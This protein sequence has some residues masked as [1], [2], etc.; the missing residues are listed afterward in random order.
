MT[1]TGTE[2]DADAGEIYCWPSG[3][4][5]VVEE[6]IRVVEFSPHDQMA[7]VLAHVV[8]KLSK[9]VRS[10][11]E[12]ARSSRTPT[13]TNWEDIVE[14]AEHITVVGQEAELL[15]H[16]AREGG[17][18]AKVPTCPGWDMRALVRHLGEIHLWAAALVAKRTSRLWPNDIS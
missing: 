4:T 10:G 12:I 5:V 7:Q 6:A 15:A 3:H 14:I 8:G 18:D 11:L 16:A 9:G 2:E 1:T 13:G 17:L